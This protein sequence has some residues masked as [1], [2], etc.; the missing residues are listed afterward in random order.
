MSFFVEDLLNSIKLRSFA[1]ISQSTLD[2]DDL[3]SLAQEELSLQLVSDLLDVREDFFTTTEDVSIVNNTSHYSIPS[4]AIG[5]SLKKLFYV[6]S[7]GEIFPLNLVDSARLA[8]YSLTGNSPESYYFAGDEVVLVPKPNQTTGSLRFL[9]AAKP[10]TLTLTENCSKI[11]LVTAGVSTVVFT[12]NTDLTASL[13]TSSY[14]DVISVKSPF[15]LWT[16]RALIQ[17][18]SATQITLLLSNVI[19]QE[20]VNVEPQ[21]GDYICP[22]G[23]ANIPQIP[24]EFHPVLSQMVNVRLMGSLGDLN[25]KQVEEAELMKLR[26]NALKLI[27]NRV[28]AS[29]KKITKRNTLITYLR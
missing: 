17:A 13:T 6:N 4:R 27:R 11:T 16:Y 23:T 12:V 18:I 1:P 14:V 19:D 15:K 9:F 29:P 25:K 10:N 20:G 28:E 5:N 24:T 21:V 26:N 7:A 2:D 8:E 22:T 3:V